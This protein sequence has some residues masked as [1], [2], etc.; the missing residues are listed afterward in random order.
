MDEGYGFSDMPKGK[1]DGNS[2]E[3]PNFNEKKTNE[4]CN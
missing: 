4:H 1:K 3:V 2:T